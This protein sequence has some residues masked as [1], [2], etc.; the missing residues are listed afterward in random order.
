ML[1]DDTIIGILHGQGWAVE[2]YS[3]YY[4]AHKKYPHKHRPPL[5]VMIEF[6]PPNNRTLKGLIH[7]C[8]RGFDK[9]SNSSD[10]ICYRFPRNEGQLLSL[11]SNIYP[12]ILRGNQDSYPVDVTYLLRLRKR[13]D[14]AYH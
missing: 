2:I 11:L 7:I 10:Y 12:V 1:D 14:R 5:R 13:Y 8:G 6:I 3:N 4:T 9:W